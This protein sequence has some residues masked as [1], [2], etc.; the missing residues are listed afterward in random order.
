M[1]IKTNPFIVTGKIEPEYFCDRVKESALLI[2]LLTNGN[3]SVLISP[4]RMGKTGLIE[5]CYDKPEIKNNYYTFFIDILHTSSLTEFT[6]VLGKEIY[7]TLVPKSH[8]M[9]NLF[10]KTLKSISGKFGFDITTGLPTFNIELGDIDSPQYTLDEIFKYLEIADKPCIISIDEFQQISKYPEKNIEAL[11]RTHIQKIENAHFVFAGSERHIMQSM[12]TSAAR[13]FYN[14]A[15]IIELNA[16]IPEM[17]IPFVVEH[18]EK[19]DRKIEDELVKKVYD[20]FKGH[21][22]YIQKIFN[23][24][25]SNTSK[26]EKCTYL[27][28]KKTIDELI[29]ENTFIFKEILSNVPAKQKALLYSIAKDGVAVNITS[30]QFIKKHNLTSASSVQSAIKILINKDLV[31]EI[32]KTYSLNDK[33]LAIWINEIY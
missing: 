11:L 23:G 28:I 15:S 25:F 26:G 12:F 32:N 21:T 24:A 27:I 3:N 22:Y 30:S 14:S 18:F 19:R 29:Q 7:Q 16:I 4:R 17:Y 8:K 1:S 2:K 5:F 10:L 13:P 6:Y 20:K 9:V 31:S 33:L